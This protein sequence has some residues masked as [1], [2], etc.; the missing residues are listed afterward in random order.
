MSTIILL[1]LSTLMSSPYKAQGKYYYLHFRDKK[2]KYM[3]SNAPKL[4]R[5]LRVKEEN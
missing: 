2:I 4:E 3:L 5:K 1:Q